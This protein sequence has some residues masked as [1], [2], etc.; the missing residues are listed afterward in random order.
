MHDMS[1]R[2][3][4]SYQP[5]ISADPSFWVSG[6]LFDNRQNLTI[7]ETRLIVDYLGLLEGCFDD[8]DEAVST[9]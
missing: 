4:P 5:E 2:F 9:T 8:E 6:Y 1:K 7:L 3:L